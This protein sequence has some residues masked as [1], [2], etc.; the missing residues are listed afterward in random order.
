MLET[1]TV[2]S[3]FST[4]SSY[5]YR[6]DPD[7][8]QEVEDIFPRGNKVSRPR[9]SWRSKAGRVLQDFQPKQNSANQKQGLPGPLE[10]LDHGSISSETHEYQQDAIA[11]ATGELTQRP[12]PPASASS[13]SKGDIQSYTSPEDQGDIQRP[14][15]PVNQVPDMQRPVSPVNHD[16]IQRLKAEVDQLRSEKERQKREQARQKAG[17][18]STATKPASRAN[19]LDYLSSKRLSWNYDTSHQIHS[20]KENE[21]FP[22]APSLSNSLHSELF[23]SQSSYPLVDQHRQ[24]E[25]TKSETTYPKKLKKSNKEQSTPKNC[26]ISEQ[27][28]FKVIRMLHENQCAIMPEV[29]QKAESS[30][31]AFERAQDATD[32]AYAE[33]EEWEI[34]ESC[35]GSSLSAEQKEEW[36][37]AKIEYGQKEGA[38]QKAADEHNPNVKNFKARA[39]QGQEV[40]QSIAKMSMICKTLNKSVTKYA[41]MPCRRTT[42]LI[43]RLRRKGQRSKAAAQALRKANMMDEGWRKEVKNKHGEYSPGGYARLAYPYKRPAEVIRKLVPAPFK[44]WEFHGWPKWAPTRTKTIWKAGKAKTIRY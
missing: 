9:K 42:A 44:S 10:N 31:Q 1:Y 16:D 28:L 8:Y 14:I 4:D 41:R 22:K 35:R 5:N 23:L 13:T 37:K 30:K 21:P 29:H 43:A 27:S 38:Q 2:D 15:S 12:T 34:A 17:F 26:Q 6:E 7:F 3:K 20:V 36:T 33:C 40:D 19:N 24:G 25:E 11:P 39:K 32:K 18:R